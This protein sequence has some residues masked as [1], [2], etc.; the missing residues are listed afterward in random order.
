MYWNG[1]ESAARTHHL[2]ARRGHPLERHRWTD[3]QGHRVEKPATVIQTNPYFLPG[4]PDLPYP[5]DSFCLRSVTR[6]S[7]N[8]ALF[9]ILDVCILSRSAARTCRIDYVYSQST[10]ANILVAE[11]LGMLT[12]DV[13]F[14]AQTNTR[15]KADRHSPK[16]A[17]HFCF[18][19][20]Y[21]FILSLDVRMTSVYFFTVHLF[22][23]ITYFIAVHKQLAFCSSLPFGPLSFKTSSFF[24][25]ILKKITQTLYF[26]HPRRLSNTT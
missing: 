8:C 16:R 1:H 21:D 15:Y 3:L 20:L 13:V 19:L 2:V 4:E 11:Y 25:L 18:T 5:E 10:C 7:L 14:P 26:S 6:S 12:F 9:S 24:L 17:K 22:N 23:L